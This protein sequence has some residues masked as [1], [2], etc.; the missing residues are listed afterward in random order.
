MKIVGCAWICLPVLCS[1]LAAR[2]KPNVLLLVTDDQRPDTI[3]SLGNDVIETPNLDRLVK[4]GT[5]FKHATCANP[6]CVPSRAEILSGC[7][8]FRNGVLG[9][10][11]ERINP[12]LTLLPVAMTSG[13]Y[14]AWYSGKWMNNGKPLTQGYDETSGLFTG[15][16]GTWKRGEVIRGRKGRSITG[17]RNWTFK[18]AKGKPDLSKG[19][20][21]TSLTDKFI[22]DGALAFLKRKTDQPFFL[23]VNFTGPHDP[24]VHPPGYKDK[25]KPA[26]MKLPLNFLSR[27]PFDHG[28]LEGRDEKLLPWPRTKADVLDEL[29]VYYA[30]IDHIDKQVGRIIEQ[31]RIDG[32]LENTYVI[33]TSDHGLALGSHGLMGK[34]NMYE[35]TIR[36]PLLIAGPGLPEGKQNNALCYLRDLYPTICDLVDLPIPKSVEGRSLKPVLY[37]KA[38]S[39]YSEIYGYFRDKQRMVRDKRWKLIHYPHIDRWQLFDLHDDPFERKDLIEDEGYVEVV[40]RLQS[41]LAR[42]MKEWEVP[43]N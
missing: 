11:A 1:V 8:S 37:G 33:Y 22:A 29:A 31:L 38:D 35:H 30:V 19:I 20:G 14:H 6:L 24:L 27:H 2:S 16:G 10:G 25:Y 23:H 32:R 36:V 12:E 26:E 34:Q 7:S 18:N 39:V 42:K 4:R 9:M 43:L 21:L 41:K 3:A 40:R 15:G 28:N 5:T 13:G 17:Y